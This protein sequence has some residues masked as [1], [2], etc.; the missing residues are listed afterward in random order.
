MDDFGSLRTFVLAVAAAPLAA[1]VVCALFERGG[2][3]RRFA[4]GFS[5]IHLAVVLGLVF[6]AAQTQDQ[7]TLD[8]GRFTPFAVP[9]A[10]GGDAS[11]TTYDLFPVGPSSP[12]KPAPA[13]QFYLGL[14]GF[15][16]P[17]VALTSL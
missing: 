2:T 17:L 9:G 13:V 14:D 10:P 15:N 4:V 16:L 5:L 6:L 11:Q 12:G 3:A 1:A 8:L 7:R